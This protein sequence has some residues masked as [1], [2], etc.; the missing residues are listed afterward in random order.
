MKFRPM[1]ERSNENPNPHE[2][3]NLCDFCNQYLTKNHHQPQPQI[4][5]F[6][7]MNKNIF[8]L[9]FKLQK[10]KATFKDVN[11]NYPPTPKKY[12]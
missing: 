6:K 4:T 8:V 9:C 11:L 10:S 7:K 1:E 12:L 2:K 3:G 5:F